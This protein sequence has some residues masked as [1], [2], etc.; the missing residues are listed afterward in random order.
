M[1]AALGTRAWL[2]GGAPPGSGRFSFWLLVPAHWHRRVR[3]VSAPI[4][5]RQASSRPGALPQGPRPLRPGQVAAGPQALCVP[6]DGSSPPLARDSPSEAIPVHFLPGTFSPSCWR[7]QTCLEEA[8]PDGEEC[9]LP[10]ICPQGPGSAVPGLGL[11]C[12]WPRSPACGCT[13][14]P[15]PQR[16]RP[17]APLPACLILCALPENLV[18]SGTSHG[19]LWF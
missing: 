8:S 5:R 4:C 6:R 14:R 7:G 15:G 10:G 12:S 18:S 9:D 2:V 3:S 1:P 19:T 16:P 11:Y 13:W 17:G